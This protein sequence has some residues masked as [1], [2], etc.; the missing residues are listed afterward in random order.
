MEI[1]TLH[2][3]NVY[4]ESSGGIRTLYHAMLTHAEK[5]RRRM[6][7]VVP[8]PEERREW[9]GKYAS[10]VFLAAPRSP[11]LDRRYRLLLPHR[12]IVPKRGRLW[13]LIDA[14]RPDVVEIGDK[15]SLC[16]FAGLMRK[17]SAAWR[18]TLVGLSCERMDDNLG[19]YI[20]SFAARRLAC[21]LLGRV[22]IGMFDAHIAVSSYV[23]DELH[24][25]MRQPHARPVHVCPMGVDAPPSIMARRKAGVR[26]Q[27]VHL[28]GA[29]GAPILLY[30]GRLAPEKQVLDLPEA[31]KAASSASCQPHLVIAGDGPLR[32]RLERTASA[33]IPGRIHFLGHISER[34]KLWEA[35][36]ACDAFVHPNP[37]EPFGIGPLEAM[38]AGAPLVAP[39]S[40]G[41]LTYATNDNAWLSGPG[42]EGLGAAIRACLENQPERRRRSANGR[43]TAELYTWSAA[44]DRLVATYRAVH[45]QRL[46]ASRS[47]ADGENLRLNRRAS[48]A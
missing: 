28:T 20:G 16:Y 12:F 32:S 30:A 26:A 27:L 15:Y 21:S 9:W 45:Q 2:L 10:I 6:T 22:Y 33:V 23:A 7:L 37:G 13:D 8:G 34:L 14:E 36:C 11:V 35:L 44:A 39:A 19:A 48:E 5:H 43:A 24:G 3:T 1:S 38:S 42:P 29:A 17:T 25:A 47:R 31:V 4:H 40:G 18:P 41:V 46:A